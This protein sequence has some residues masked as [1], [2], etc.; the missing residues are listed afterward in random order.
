MKKK[1]VDYVRKHP[2]A[3][4][5]EIGGALGVWHI[6]LVKDIH[7]LVDA[8]ILVTELHSDPANMDTYI[9]YSVR[10]R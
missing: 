3:R 4:L 9:M 5:R 2:R 7:E 1:I 6:S 8:G 10:E